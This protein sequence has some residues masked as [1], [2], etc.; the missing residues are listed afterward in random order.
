MAFVA[1][2]E[3]RSGR[4]CRSL[5]A[6]SGAARAG[7]RD[8]SRRVRRRLRRTLFAYI[9]VRVPPERPR[10]RADS[11]RKRPCRAMR[12]SLSRAG[13]TC[14]ERGSPCSVLRSRRGGYL[15]YVLVV[16]APQQRSPRRD[17]MRRGLAI[18]ITRALSRM[19]RPWQRWARAPR[20]VCHAAIARWSRVVQLD[21]MAR[22]PYDRHL[23]CGV[24]DLPILVNR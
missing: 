21:I 19:T 20:A 18:L 5:R 3:R 8:R 24:R 17:C 1:T 22:D 2:R 7:A 9:S 13:S 23:A 15:L 4:A 6:S 16:A 14:S 10:R 12:G 11:D